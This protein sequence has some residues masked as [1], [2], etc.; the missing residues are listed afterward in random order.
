M[1]IWQQIPNSGIRAFDVPTANIEQ[2][3][4]PVDQ[5]SI[6]EDSTGV[7]KES[8]ETASSAKEVIVN[9]FGNFNTPCM[10]MKF[11]IDKFD[12]TGDFG[13]WRRKVK[14]LLSQQ[15][16]LKAIEGPD[17]LP[18]TLSPEQKDDMLEMALGTIILNLSDNVLREVNDETTAYDYTRKVWVYLLKSKDLAFESFKAWKQLVENQTSKKVK[19]LRTDNGLKFCKEEFNKFCCDHGIERHRTV[20]Y[21]PQ[22]NGVVER[23]KMTILDKPNPNE[24]DLATSSDSDQVE[25][26]QSQP[27]IN[28]ESLADYELVRDRAKRIIKPNSKYAYADEKV[29]SYVKVDVGNGSFFV[30]V[31]EEATQVCS[32]W[33][34]QF[35]GLQMEDTFR[36]NKDGSEVEERETTGEKVGSRGQVRTGGCE[37]QDT[38]GEWQTR[39]QTRR[40]KTASRRKIETETSSF[41]MSEEDSKFSNPPRKIDQEKGKMKWVPKP[42]KLVQKEGFGKLIIG[43]RQGQMGKGVVSDTTSTLIEEGLLSDFKRWRGVCSRKEPHEEGRDSRDF[44]IPNGFSLEGPIKDYLANIGK[45][46]GPNEKDIDIGPQ[47]VMFSRSQS[48]EGPL[49][50]YLENIEQAFIRAKFRQG[51][52]LHP[53][54]ALAPIQNTTVERSI[55]NNSVSIVQ[56]TN[57]TD[58]EESIAQESKDTSDSVSSE[59]E[60]DK[61]G[62]SFKSISATREVGEVV[63]EPT[64]SKPRKVHKSIILYTTNEYD[65]L[66]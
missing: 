42:R 13:I 14:A 52:F 49:N 37:A 6:S 16:I 5:P 66:N 8:S 17:K 12:G 40:R 32:K 24:D 65:D 4:P 2:E 19:V 26:S 39:C 44:Q 7:E 55:P 46:G 62:C 10:S 23:M 22:Q 1:V 59:A 36:M 58:E 28:M 63:S 43:E 41:E 25:E 15:K 29:S 57:H 20:R 56:E 35:L 60:D 48:L 33:I 34:E 45:C 53:E 64:L 27:E 51:L 38:A 54:Q 21:T 18:G 61:D 3:D 31:K 30:T 47:N 11:D 50:E 9:N